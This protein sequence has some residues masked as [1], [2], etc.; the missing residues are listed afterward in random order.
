[1]RQSRRERTRSRDIDHEDDNQTTGTV[2]IV[3]TD[4]HWAETPSAY[5]GNSV[6]DVDR[7]INLGEDRSAT[8]QYEYHGIENDHVNP[9]IPPSAVGTSSYHSMSLAYGRSPGAAVPY[10]THTQF[11]GY[12]GI[13]V[14]SPTARWLD[15]LI[16][17]ATVDNGPLPD[18]E[19][20][21]NGLDVFGNSVAQSPV[22]NSASLSLPVK[23]VAAA[24]HT[25]RQRNPFSATSCDYLKE[26]TP[27][28][29][30][31]KR[32]ELAWKAIE[33][34]ELQKHETILLRHYAEHIS[35][36]V[37]TI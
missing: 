5:V 17:D 21:S 26:R 32:E 12:P 34:V 25:S 35:R 2:Q 14:D 22:S 37:S 9:P 6:I 27:Y 3:A 29:G 23:A 10:Q 7:A 30:N 19:Y 8:G 31:Q 24:P 20:D 4:A 11:T 18:W 28:V 36:W 16:G 13:A 15:L 1:M 33:P